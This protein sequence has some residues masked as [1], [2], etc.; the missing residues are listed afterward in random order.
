MSRVDATDDL[1]YS[2]DAIA[3]DSAERRAMAAD[4]FV[5]D[6][7]GNCHCDGYRKRY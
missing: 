1:D 5:H 7:R 6:K 4:S 3:G 2:E